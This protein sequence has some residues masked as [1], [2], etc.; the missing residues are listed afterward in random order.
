MNGK[1]D[2]RACPSDGELSFLRNMVEAHIA[3]HGSLDSF[4]IRAGL[5]LEIIDRANTRSSGWED[6]ATA[7]KDG[8]HILA[9]WVLKGGPP[10]FGVV[11]WDSLGSWIENAEKVSGFNHW[12]PL[13]SPP[14]ENPN[15]LA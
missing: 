2:L 3:R 9:C 14:S 11:F 4:M 1:N 8:T 5:L 12:M 6:I 15:E 10:L 7:P 13:P